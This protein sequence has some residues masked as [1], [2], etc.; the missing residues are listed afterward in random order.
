MVDTTD[1]KVLRKRLQLSQT[2]LGKICG[3]SGRVISNIETGKRILTQEEKEKLS[4]YCAEKGI[5]AYSLMNTDQSARDTLVKIIVKKS[6]PA[7]DDVSI[8]EIAKH[9][10]TIRE[11]IKSL[12]D[13][14]EVSCKL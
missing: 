13:E 11:A 10:E 14:W 5:D 1:M 3:L 4:Q 7:I 9:I 2:E 12:A 8:T 6:F